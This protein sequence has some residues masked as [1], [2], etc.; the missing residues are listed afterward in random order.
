MR[1]LRVALERCVFAVAY[2]M[3]ARSRRGGMR[4]R[5]RLALL[6]AADLGGL[7]LEDLERWRI[8]GRPLLGDLSSQDSGRLFEEELE[9]LKLLLSKL[10]G[11]YGLALNEDGPEAG[12]VLLGENPSRDYSPA[13]A[14]AAAL[15]AAAQADLEYFLKLLFGKEGFRPGQREAVERLLEGRDAFVL[16]PTGSGK[17]LVFQL[18]ACLLPGV[19][20]VVEPTLSLIEDQVRLLRGSGFEKVSAITSEIENGRLRAKALR[21]LASGRVQFCYVSPER[22]QTASLRRALA[23]LA[24]EGGFALAAVDEAHCV[25]EWGHDFRVAYLRAAATLRSIAP[26]PIAALTGTASPEV[27]AESRRLLGMGNGAA[28]ID[29]GRGPAENLRFHIARCKADRKF[30]FLERVLERV[31]RSGSGI[32]FFPAVEGE[33]GARSAASRLRALGLEVGVYH[34]KPPRGMEEKRWR[35]E[36][37]GAASDFLEG[38]VPLLAATKAFGLGIDKPDVRFTVHLGL[39]SSVEAFRQEAGRC[40]RDG[41]PADCWLVLSLEDERR[42]RRLLDPSLSQEEAAAG[43]EKAARPFDDA[44]SALSLHLASHPGEAREWEDLRLVLERLG[45]ASRPGVIKLSM[46]LQ[47]QPLIEKALYRLCRLGVA[48]DY[49]VRYGETAFEVLLTGARSKHI[50]SAL[51]GLLEERG[52]DPR[53]AFPRGRSDLPSER[54]F[55]PWA[56][57]AYLRLVYGTIEKERRSSLGKMLHCALAETDKEFT[58]RLESYLA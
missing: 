38:R 57:K 21:D 46:P 19:C 44:L 4:G 41:R 43:L 9:E 29:M 51:A 56:A 47:H 30:D 28:L 6:A 15:P 49:A 39:P 48:A 13:P 40:G 3:L 7:R 24:R 36:K 23:H 22:L 16:L 50:A 27:L 11:L 26:A 35:K 8:W 58:R 53:A 42:A 12:L 37:R 31:R 5:A 17:S 18:A 54:E 2:K 10:C 1:V 20:L 45:D 14:R 55:L 52:L 25:S 32:M 33:R 34:G